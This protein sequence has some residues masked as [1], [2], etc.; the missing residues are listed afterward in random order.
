MEE[1]PKTDLEKSIARSWQDLL[2]CGPVKRDDN[3]FRLG[4]HSLLAIE[5]THR[6]EQELGHP[7]PARELFAGPTPRQFAARIMEIVAKASTAADVTDLATENQRDFWIAEQSGFDTRGFN[8]GLTLVVKGNLPEDEAWTTAWSALVARHASLRTGFVEDEHCQLRSRVEPAI[9]ADFALATAPDETAALAAIRDAQRKPFTMANPGLWRGGLTR[10]AHGGRVIFWLSLHHAA[11]DGLSVG[12]LVEEMELLLRGAE[13]PAAACTFAQ[14]A[15]RQDAYLHSI[16]EQDDSHYWS[17][18]MAA[19]AAPLPDGTSPFDEGPL[20]MARPATRS[21]SS[22]SSSHVL[23]MELDAHVAEGLQRLARRNGASFHALMLT[24]LAIELRRRN[25]RHA[26]VL[27][28]SVSTRERADEARTV[29]NFVNLIPIPCRLEDEEQPE[30]ILHRVQATLSEGLRHAR[31]P[32]S[33]IVQ[34]FRRD[35]GHAIHPARFPL[36]DFAVSENPAGKAATHTGLRFLP[37]NASIQSETSYELASGSPVQDALLTHQIRPDGGM[38]LQLIMNAAIYEVGTAR[39]W[40]KAIGDWARHLSEPT[41]LD[42]FPIPELLHAEE[43]Q[44]AT[45]E[46]GTSTRLPE[47]RLH[48]WVERLAEQFPERPAVLLDH[49]IITYGELDQRANALAHAMLEGGIS[50]G[51]IIGVLTERAPGLTE[52]ILGIWKAGCCYL[53]LTRDLPAARLTHMAQEAGAALI[54]ALDDSVLPA[55]LAAFNLPVLRPEELTHTWRAAHAHKPEIVYRN[56]PEKD[57]AYII[58]TSGSTGTPKGVVLSQL[59]TANLAFGVQKKY[60]CTSEDRV[61]TVSSPSFDASVSDFVLAWA[62]GAALVPVTD[63]EMKDITTMRAKFTR[64]R[65][66]CATMSPSYL[67]LFNET[68]LE[69]LKVLATVGEA[70]I[71][72]DIARFAPRLRYI[73]GYGPSEYSAA[74]SIGPLS[75]GRRPAA[76]RPIDNTCIKIL[77]VDGKRVPPGALGELW[78]SGAGMGLGYIGRPELTAERFVSIDGIMTY[79]TGDLAR[80][81]PDGEV[82]I[83]GRIDNQVKLRGQRIE[84]EEID[85]VIESHPAAA[86]A[87]AAIAT[88][89]DGQQRLWAFAVI[90]P[91]NPEPTQAEWRQHLARTLPS[92]MLPFAILPVV[93]I[94][95]SLAGKID[96]KALLTELPDGTWHTADDARGSPAASTAALSHNEKLISEVWRDVLGIAPIGRNDHFF[97]C[98]GD[99]LRAIAAIARLRKD[100]DCNT[101]DLYEYPVLADFAAVCRLLPGRV[102]DLAEET[103]Q[104]WLAY[105]ARRS[106]FEAQRSAAMQGP[107]EAY[108]TRNQ[109]YYSRRLEARRPYRKILLTGTTGYLGSYLL[110]EMLKPGDCQVVAPVRAASREEAEAR[111][112]A[113][114]SDYFGAAAGEAFLRNPRLEVIPADLSLVGLGLPQKHF[115]ALAREIDAIINCAANTRHY[116]HYAQFQ[117]GNVDATRNLLDLAATRG[118]GSADMHHVSTLSVLAKPPSD[119]FIVRT[120]YNGPPPEPNENYYIRSKQEAEELV[121]ASRGK[122]TNASIFRTGNIIAAT[123]GPILQRNIDE[124]A[125][126]GMLKAIF[127]VG[128]VPND[129]HIAPC[130]VD[131]AA[132]AIVKLAFTE[133][134]AN[135]IHHIEPS[136]EQTLAEFMNAG[137]TQAV[138]DMN[139][140]EFMSV[141]NFAVTQPELEPHAMLLM[142]NFGVLKGRSPHEAGRRLTVQTKRTEFL[143]EKLGFSWPAHVTPGQ[144]AMIKAAAE[145]K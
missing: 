64:H 131:R 60:G 138:S 140:A 55:E 97:E 80:W 26:F 44:L 19:A 8:V 33:R 20:D 21:A 103:R 58:Y 83:A 54:V 124:N 73:N 89:S 95:V 113:V 96:R 133:E 143:L 14:V 102:Q 130:S 81:T 65:V 126:F 76:G 61:L 6:L 108:A 74:T 9:G 38:T 87:I 27:G 121:I 51:A 118:G 30:K 40:I 12:L 125:F 107:L 53:P 29:G 116:G 47:T 41:R 50:A 7:V 117:M 93:S 22:E 114:L 18:A 28:T 90:K 42:A 129:T 84:L 145:A 10:T 98:G 16:A 85:R 77:G 134:L 127:R 91:E 48:S 119:G 67:R 66:T 120:E 24:V 100:F 37:L 17:R 62:A 59:G 137:S 2:Q 78:I 43:A 144:H 99:S 109:A 111:L 139:F 11:V 88:G 45:W 13:L 31:Y 105:D 69:A 32:M 36:F 46:N 86:Q 79:R 39:Q 104:H 3:F 92:Y 135:E 57:P 1:A 25:G 63:K 68:D 75:A 56:A 72:A 141:L 128:A 5:S 123:D 142:E 122:L 94:P 70:P 52:T 71:A 101:N 82:E 132:A 34:S 49:Q 110:R 4:G 115:T 136:Q 23:R 35:V 106:H 15:A 112:Q